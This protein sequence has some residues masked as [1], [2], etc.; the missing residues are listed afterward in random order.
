MSNDYNVVTLKDRGLNI[1][2]INGQV[3]AMNYEGVDLVH[4]GSLPDAL[5]GEGCLARIANGAPNYSG[6]EMSPFIG[7]SK[8][9]V[10]AGKK[11][12]NYDTHGVSRSI[13]FKL[14][15]ITDDNVVFYQ[16]HNGKDI[17]P[18]VKYDRS[19][20]GVEKLDGIYDYELVKKF[21]LNNGVNVE[22]VFR[23]TGNVSIWH[24]FGTHPLF[25][26]PVN[27]DNGLFVINGRDDLK[28]SDVLKS[29]Y[30]VELLDG[31]NDVYFVNKETGVGIEFKHDFGNTMIWTP[32]VESGIFGFEPK[33]LS[34]VRGKKLTRDGRRVLPGSDDV[35][36]L[37][38]NPVSD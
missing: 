24:D 14:V 6:L 36:S 5:K 3:A 38:I 29:D 37:S 22:H 16:E 11:I 7:G 13:P 21:G 35:F 26:A 12:E 17:I 32:S 20:G 27:Y 34:G 19:K 1:A 8:D 33:T 31:V 9:G 10:W 15:D 28:L 18:N 2:L 23:N 4:Q 25:I 30:N